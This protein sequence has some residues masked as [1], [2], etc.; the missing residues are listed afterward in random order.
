MLSPDISPKEE[1]ITSPDMSPRF[2]SVAEGS[3]KRKP[4]DDDDDGNIKSVSLPGFQT[5]LPY[6]EFHGRP[7]TINSLRTPSATPEPREGDVYP[8]QSGLLPGQDPIIEK[9]NHLRIENNKQP[10]KPLGSLCT[11]DYLN[12]ASHK[13]M[14]L[15]DMHNEVCQQP[16][17]PREIR[18]RRAKTPKTTH[19]NIKYLV[20]ELDYIRYHRVDLQQKWMLVENNY[21]VMFPMARETQGLQGVNY[22]QNNI[23]PHIH[24]NMLV[25]MENG[26]VESVCVKT[27]EQTERKHLYTLVYLFPDR[28]MRYPWVT[29][30]HRERARELSK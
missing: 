23:L 20:E 18:K 28:A 16:S 8:V 30:S 29:P 24:N 27:K 10:L 5:L 19:C 3:L 13:W 15:Q 12:Q 14:A 9:L 25:F 7:H 2:M 17:P 4:E 22:R 1:P 21:R 11:P 26:H 6:P